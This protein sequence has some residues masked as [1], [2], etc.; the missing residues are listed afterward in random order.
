ML[1]TVSYIELSLGRGEVIG[2]SC[3][4]LEDYIS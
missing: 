1:G 2:S 4:M 3:R